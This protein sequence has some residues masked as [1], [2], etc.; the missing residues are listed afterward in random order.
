[1]N[2]IENTS[3]LMDSFFEKIALPVG[4]LVVLGISTSEISGGHI[5]KQS[6]PEIGKDVVSTICAALKERGIYL[7]VQCCEHLNRALVMETDTARKFGC[8]PVSVRPHPTAGGSGGA[9][10]FE[11]FDSP[12]VVEAVRADAG[13]DIGVTMIGMHLRPVAVPVRT[14]V[15][16]GAARVDFAYS[17]PK[18]IGGPRARYD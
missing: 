8:E 4:S 13:I 12:C 17:R 5:G 7:A 14:A 18:L 16:L 15:T 11:L 2:Y 10:A 6:S 1:M 3:R 9:A